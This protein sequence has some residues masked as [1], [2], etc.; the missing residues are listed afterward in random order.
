MPA[1][2]SSLAITLPVPN[3]ADAYT[4]DEI[5]WFSVQNLTSR[6]RTVRVGDRIFGYHS[7]GG[8]TG[9]SVDGQDLFYCRWFSSGLSLQS[10]FHNGGNT[11]EGESAVEESLHGDLICRIQRTGGGSASFL[12]LVRKFQE[13][14]FFQIRG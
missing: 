10:F 11:R 7:T 13:F 5:Q 9:S 1:A 4:I 2:K 6:S 14:E 8:L 12:G 3:P